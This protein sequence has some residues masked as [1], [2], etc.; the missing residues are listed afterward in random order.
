ME[1]EHKKPLLSEDNTVHDLVPIES[2]DDGDIR[3]INSVADFF[4]EFFSESR[5]LW[6]LAAPTIFNNVAI[7]GCGV[8]TQI[9]SGHLSTTQLAAISMENFVISSISVGLLGGLGSGLETLCGQAYGA[10]HLDMLGIYLQKSWIIL[11][12]VAIG[13]VFLF[14]FAT[15][16]LNLLRQDP[17]ISVEAGKFARMMIPQHFAFAMY[18]PLAKFLQAQSK[19]LEMAGIAGIA[20]CLHAISGWILMMKLRWGLF[21]A[22][23]VLNSTWWFIVMCP[24]LFVVSGY[25]GGAWSGFSWKAFSNLFDFFKLSISAALMICLEMWYVMAMTLAAG[26]LPN[27]KVSVAAL[28]ICM[29]IN[30]WSGMV[31]I[32]FNSAISVRVSNTLGSGHPR[33]AKFSVIVV[34]ATSF[35]F[36]FVVASI[37]LL[38]RKRFPALFTDNKQIQLLVE[39]LTPFLGVTIVLNCLQNALYGVTIGAGWQN[40]VGYINAACYLFLGVPLGVLLGFKFDMGIKG[41]WYGLL[42]GLFLQAATILLV[43]CNKNWEVE[44]DTVR[45]RLKLL[46]KM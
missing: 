32:G 20:V 23:L 27:P 4:R 29:N 16:I 24:L 38:E 11:N 46:G 43:A 7:Y 41:I 26:Y 40:L 5:K 44:A 25:C 9:Y 36:G 37:L 30:G 12:S 39:D 22:A 8:L 13:L 35:L 31:G 21:G 33:A 45:A 18:V 3:E 1:H 14:L 10:K 34:G 28:S 15:Q 17:E 19:V 6:Y 2:L 42:L